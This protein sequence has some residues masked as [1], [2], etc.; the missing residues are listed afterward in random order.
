MEFKLQYLRKAIMID[1]DY[2]R[3]D[4]V[5]LERYHQNYVRQTDGEIVR[6]T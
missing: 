2:F 1:L 4:L 3:N 6:A 5:E